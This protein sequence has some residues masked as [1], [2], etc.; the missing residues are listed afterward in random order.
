MKILKTLAGAIALGTLAGACHA[1]ITTVSHTHMDMPSMHAGG[2]QLPAATQAQIDKMSD[3]TTYMSGHK[4]RVDTVM[5]S[6]ISDPDT[7]KMWSLNNTA[8]TYSVTAVDPAQI[9]QMVQTLT[10]SPGAGA[11]GSNFKVTD[12]G[13]TT[14]ILGHT[15][16]HYLVKMT[17]TIMGRTT[18]MTQDILAAQDLPAADM[19]LYG[20]LSGGAGQIHGLPLVTTTKFVGGFSDGMT[21]KQV[22]TSISMDPIP[23]STF[24]VPDG[25]TQTESKGMF[26]MGGFGAR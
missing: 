16:R 1:D 11:P 20:G 10:K 3:S 15:A 21:M 13:R 14:K 4:M 7:G 18:T 5:M 25:Y 23:A 8:H 12:T 9:K 6:F 22:V 24:T 17:M 26:P 2:A 19:G